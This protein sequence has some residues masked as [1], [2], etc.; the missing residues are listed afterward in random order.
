M[1]NSKKKSLV[2]ISGVTG[3][4]GG[5]L[6]T[7]FGQRK[8]TIVYG[9]SRK[10]EPVSLFLNNNKLPI[11]TLACSIG[12]NMDFDSLFQKIDVD[13]VRDITYIHCFGLYPFEVDRNGQ[14]VV[15]NDIDG[16]GVNDEVNK[17]TYLSFVNA[18]SILQKYW[19]GKLSC[20][21]FAGLAD[22]HRPAGHKS[23]WTTIEK[24]KNYMR[25]SVEMNKNLSMMV[26]NISSVLCPHEVITRP[27]VFIQTDAD[28]RFWLNPYEL[29]KFVVSKLV[30]ASGYNEFD[31][32]RSK[33]GF[34]ESSYYTDDVFTPRKVKELFV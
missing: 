30:S 10:A 24:V 23:W 17:L 13:N 19:K 29:A 12:D 22:K 34:D 28:P 33:P 26:F 16:D 9:L 25:S 11:A 2:I 31:K 27:F 7:V 20:A 1:K 8:D 15:S 6:L 21:I 32:F 14:I 4:I 5:A 18:T 3:A